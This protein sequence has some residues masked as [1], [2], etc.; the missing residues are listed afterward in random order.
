MVG[1]S[2]LVSFFSAAVIWESRLE[3]I[4]TDFLS[5]VLKARWEMGVVKRAT[6]GAAKRADFRRKDI[7]FETLM[8]YRIVIL[9]VNVRKG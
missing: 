4:V 5:V 8:V 2:F 6:V 3:S 1:P 9:W 7:L